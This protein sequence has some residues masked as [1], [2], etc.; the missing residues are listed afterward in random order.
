VAADVA[1]VHGDEIRKRAESSVEIVNE[2]PLPPLAL[3]DGTLVAELVLKYVYPECFHPSIPEM[4]PFEVYPARQP[5]EQQDEADKCK[6][7]PRI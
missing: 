4:F 2:C 1:V 5:H 6:S 7:S 3:R